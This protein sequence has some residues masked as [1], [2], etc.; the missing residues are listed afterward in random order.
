MKDKS[1]LANSG[2]ACAFLLA[3]S[4]AWATGKTPPQQS[5]EEER[6]PRPEPPV[7][8][9]NEEKQPPNLAGGGKSPKGQQ[10][11]SESTSTEATGE[12]SIASIALEKADEKKVQTCTVPKNVR[13]TQVPRPNKILSFAFE[14]KQRQKVSLQFTMSEI[15]PADEERILV[16]L[17]SQCLSPQPIFKTSRSKN[18]LALLLDKD[19][20]ESLGT[21]PVPPQATQVNTFKIDLEMD[22]LAQQ[23]EAGNSTFYFQAGLLNKNDFYRRNYDDVILSPLEA[24]HFASNTCPN[25]QQFSKRINTKNQ[26]CA[27]MPTKTD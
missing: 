18:Q 27:Q 17:Y 24:L 20:I 10:S 16:V 9:Q 14:P 26:S 8:S 5:E 3:T 4:S 25:E 22:K 2:V 15:E 11:E 12:I 13:L 21:Y 23:I 1:K 7:R 19:N 6:T